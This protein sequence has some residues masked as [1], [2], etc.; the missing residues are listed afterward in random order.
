MKSPEDSLDLQGATVAHKQ[1]VVIISVYAEYLI[2]RVFDTNIV[3]KLK[4]EYF[5]IVAFLFKLLALFYISALS[6]KS[7]ALL[8]SGWLGSAFAWL[9][10]L[11]SMSAAAFPSRCKCCCCFH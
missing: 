3:P 6:L 8:R 4:N 2:L 9:M 10:A 5:S 11:K 7:C 1:T